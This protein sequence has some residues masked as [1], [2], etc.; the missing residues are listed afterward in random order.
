[1]GPGFVRRDVPR[2]FALT[3]RMAR[4]FNGARLRSPECATT[5][6]TSAST[7]RSLQWGPAS[8]AGMCD[9]GDRWGES[10]CGL[11]W[12]PASFAGMCLVHRHPSRDGDHPS[13][14]PGFVRRDVLAVL[15]LHLQGLR[16]S[17][18]PG[19]VRRDVRERRGQPQWSRGPS[20]GPG[21]VRRDVP[22]RA[23][24][25]TLHRRRL[26][27]GPAS[28]A[29]MCIRCRALGASE[30]KPTF[31]GARLRSP[32]CADGLEGLAPGLG[33]FNGARLRSPGCARGRSTRPTR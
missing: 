7:S 16:P 6:P 10:W 31:N 18:G 22:K 24:P 17:M 23:P 8:F 3:S 25:S 33:A 27:W 30:P 2:A 12:G 21:F 20:M 28:F 15:V 19:F 9:G 13:M 11:Q 32:G 5:P 14:G 4:R 29:G 26:Q 1:M